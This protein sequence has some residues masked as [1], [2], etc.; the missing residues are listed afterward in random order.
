MM[1][2]IH[3]EGLFSTCIGGP[4]GIGNKKNELNNKKLQN[5]NILNRGVGATKWFLS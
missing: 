1:G 2:S 4:N 3:V 5:K